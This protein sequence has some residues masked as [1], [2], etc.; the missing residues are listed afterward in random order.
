[1]LK[2]A[3]PGKHKGLVLHLVC[4][5]KWGT[6]LRML[7]LPGEANTKPTSL[8]VTF[9]HAHSLHR[10]FLAETSCFLAIFSTPGARGG[11]RQREPF[12]DSA[13]QG[14]ERVSPVSYLYNGHPRDLTGTKN[15][16]MLLAQRLEPTGQLFRVVQKRRKQRGTRAN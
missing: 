9:G 3:L 4:P 15:I 6:S 1:M 7:I 16:A 2:P 10:S 8:R 12:V 14:A 13:A 11:G 5:S